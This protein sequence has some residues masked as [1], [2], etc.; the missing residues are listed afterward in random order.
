MNID[1]LHYARADSLCRWV[2]EIG[3]G[4]LASCLVKC[5]CMCVHACMHM[6]VKHIHKD[7]RSFARVH[8]WSFR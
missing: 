5:R 3:L 8:L 7:R 6:A 1:H 2:G 4:S